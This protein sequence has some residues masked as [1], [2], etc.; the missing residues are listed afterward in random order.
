MLEAITST[1]H[2]TIFS[3]FNVYERRLR[4]THMQRWRTSPLKSHEKKKDVIIFAA[5]AVIAH[6]G[7]SPQNT[8]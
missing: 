4:V 5:A 2:W 8:L 7:N 3:P 6:R 1:Y